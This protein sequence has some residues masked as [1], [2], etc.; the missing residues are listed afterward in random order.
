MDPYQRGLCEKRWKRAAR[1]V[2]T[3]QYAAAQTV[4]ETI[5]ARTPNDVN[6]LV[7][8]ADMYLAQRH[9]RA[10]CAELCRVAR[11]LP[12]SLS[13]I[14]QIAYRLYRVGESRAMLQCL[15][16]P[17][18]VAAQSPAELARVAHMWQLLG[19]HRRSLDAM[20][21]AANANFDE[22]EFGYRYGMELLFNGDLRAAQRVLIRCANEHPGLGRAVLALVRMDE[23]G[24]EPNHLDMINRGIRQT[25]EE[26]VDRA[27]LEFASFKELN[28]AG[29]YEDA[30]SSLVRGNN[31]MRTCTKYDT[32]SVE[33]HVDAIVRICSAQFVQA[34]ARRVTGPTPIFIV[35]LPRSG[36]TLVERIISNHPQVASCGE[37]EDFPRQMQWAADSFSGAPINDSMLDRA[38][39]LDYADIGRRYLQQTRWRAGGKPYYTDKLPENFAFAGF[40]HKALPN[41][42]I[43]H[44]VRR[45]TDVCFSNWST[46][47]SSDHGYSYGLGK[48]LSYYNQYQALMSH[49]RRTM[50]DAILDVRYDALVRDMQSTTEQMLRFCGLAPEP[51]CWDVTRNAA[52]IATLSAAQARRPIYDHGSGAWYPY[53]HELAALRASLAD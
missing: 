6:A 29:R 44:V 34:K 14:I 2:A 4:L 8:R 49:W 35:G 23:K 16:S 36:T 30:W 10:A 19:D 31:I 22:P 33:R 18:V 24:R 32:A 7:L 41:A 37:L 43:L 45:P 42:R 50:P 39:D 9:L 13:A 38:R 1:Y 12:A 15:T 51:D 28:R 20:E 48:I 3:G 53:R 46:L 27:A 40:I 17:T 47:F 52:P 26:S 5:L 25:S 11:E 21:R